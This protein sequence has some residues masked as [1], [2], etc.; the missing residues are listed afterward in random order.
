M[1]SYAYGMYSGII[2]FLRFFEMLAIGWL[3]DLFGM[4]ILYIIFVLVF[5]L[6]LT[7]IL[8]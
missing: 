8:R 7:A 2:F 4:R 1:R 5:L 6:S 3:A